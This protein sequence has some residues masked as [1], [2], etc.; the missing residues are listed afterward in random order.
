MERRLCIIHITPKH[1]ESL[2]TDVAYFHRLFRKVTIV[3]INHDY[4]K[5]LV[6]VTVHNPKFNEVSEGYEIPYIKPLIYTEYNLAF[7]INEI[8][9]IDWGDYDL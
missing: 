7:G 1:W 8:S 3:A 4:N 9:K 2:Y 6:L 5:G